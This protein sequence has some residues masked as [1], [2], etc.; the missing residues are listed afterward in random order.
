[1]QLETIPASAFAQAF[2]RIDPFV[3][4]VDGPE[5][6]VLFEYREPCK[7]PGTGWNPRRWWKTRR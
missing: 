2:E 4:T 7:H 5:R 3:A 1:M 6:A